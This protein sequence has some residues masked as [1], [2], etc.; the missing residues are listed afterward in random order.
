MTLNIR[1][2]LFAVSLALIAVSTIAAELYLRND[3]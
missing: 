1:A 2:K 3:I